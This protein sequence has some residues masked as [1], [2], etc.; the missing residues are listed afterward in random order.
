MN[1]RVE[2]SINDTLSSVKE[3]YDQRLIE[4]DKMLKDF[5]QKHEEVY[6]I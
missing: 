1:A 2:T 4:K 3:D 6:S 5:M